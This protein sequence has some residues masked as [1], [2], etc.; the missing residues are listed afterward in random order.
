MT[1]TRRSF[2]ASLGMASVR[3]ADPRPPNVV[4]IISDDHGWTDYGFMGHPDVR[5]PHLDRIAREGLTFTR[6]YVPSSLCRPS[7]ASI[8]TGLY[9]HQHRIT[10]ND[11]AGDARDPANRSR[12]V[13]VFEQSRTIAGLLG[14][15]GYRSHQSGK[16]WEGPCQ[17]GGFTECMTHGDVR[18]GGRH[19]DEGLAIGRETMQPVFDFIDRAQGEPFFLWYAPFLPHTPHNPP[20]RLLDRYRVR[21]LA[22]D[23]A[24]YYAMIEWLDETVGALLQ[25]LERRRL[26][27]NT[28]LVYL[29][30]NGWVQR[31]GDL[32]FGGRSKLSP[33]DA[34]VRTPLLLRW[35]GR[36]APRREE[37]LAVSS[38]D[39]ATTILPACGVRPPA[40]LPGVNLLDTR[41][42]A[43][44][45][46]V[47]GS[48]FVHT[49]V[50]INRPAANLKYRWVVRGTWKLIA[51]Y[52]PNRGLELWEGRGR[53]SWMKDDPELFDLAADPLEE[54]DLAPR[55]PGQ[56]RRLLAELDRW[57]TPA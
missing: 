32:P 12:M 9:P 19:G 13:K 24:S 45:K 10:G 30:D 11:P 26:D 49:S 5:T 54:R 22:R 8:M 38:V 52:P 14:E 34:G 39:L 44:R 17:C 51:P 21:A 18:R 16:W 3:A 42:V 55:R 41:S 29:A 43:R 48:I 35:P 53:P 23:V 15:R 28:L 2:L 25:H 7:L 36:I 27:G 57:W 46:A 6:G 4:L 33:Y 31:G 47:F 20:D 56:V 50:D 37:R 40:A 1:S